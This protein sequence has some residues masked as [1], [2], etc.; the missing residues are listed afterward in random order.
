LKLGRGKRSER[1]RHALSTLP[2]DSRRQF[3]PHFG[4]CA[5]IPTTFETLPAARASPTVTQTC[6]DAVN[7]EID[8]S[9]HALIF[10][11]GAMPL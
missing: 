4:D 10:V 9:L 3:Q 7:R 11:A 2:R 8:S 5:T 6:S 1:P